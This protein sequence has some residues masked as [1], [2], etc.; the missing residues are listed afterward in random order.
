VGV[1]VGG[2]FRITGILGEGDKGR[3]YT[4]DWQ[5]G[6]NVHKVAVKLLLSHY[7]KD[8]QEVARFMREC[9]TVR[10][11]EHPSTIKLFDFGQIESGQIYIAMELL[12]GVSLEMALQNGPLPPE[13]VDRIL[14]QVCGA[15]QEAHE[16]GIVHRDLKPDN[17]YLTTHAGQDVVK[18]LDFGM[19][20]HDEQLAKQGT[21][22]GTPPYMSPEQFR[23][24]QLDARSDIY[25]LGVVTYEMLT[26]RLPFERPPF[27]AD[28]PWFW[29]TEHL[30]AQP[31]P[32]ET[33]PLGRQV[34]TKMRAAVM[35]ALSKDVAHRQQT[36][37]DLYEEL[38]LGTS[39]PALPDGPVPRPP[40]PVKEG[41]AVL[42]LGVVLVLAVL[43]GV[44]GGGATFHYLQPEDEGLEACK[45]TIAAA[46]A[47]DLIAALDHYK[48][49]GG[50]TTQARARNAI[51]A[52]AQHAADG[53]DCTGLEAARA[54]DRIGLPSALNRMKA[55][56]CL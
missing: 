15:L 17:I 26:G 30:T 39:G 55:K 16:K 56:H 9:D 21:V 50:Q 2:R 52:A 14:G 27:Q 49:C 40:P 19:A 25:S 10:E 46:N 1:I 36:M 33:L 42:L 24:G 34:P 45:A 5:M 31:V 35:R 3:V 53:P 41:K 11:L 4:A 38:M 12:S 48:A 54:A 20:K 22:L 8:P 29:A 37:K 28:T 7:A 23:G 32:L 6:T 13:R 51:D 44:A 47:G 43:G 18:V